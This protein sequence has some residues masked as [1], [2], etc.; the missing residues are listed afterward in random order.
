MAE[1]SVSTASTEAGTTAVADGGGAPSTTSTEPGLLD[2]RSM[3]PAELQSD[4]TLANYKTLDAA[5]KTLIE[6]RKML[7]RALFLPEEGAADA[8]A[9]LAKVYDKLGRPADATQYKITPPE[10]PEGLRWDP[11]LEK[12]FREEAYVAGLTQTQVDRLLAFEARRTQQMGNLLQAR[13]AEQ[14]RASK[15]TLQKTFGASA[16]RMQ[17]EAIAFFEQFGRGAFGGDQGKTALEVF[18]N[19]YT[20]D[21][22]PLK[23]HPAVV[24]AFAQAY[25]CLSEDSFVTSE[26]SMAGV[27]NAEAMTTRARELTAKQLSGSLNASEQAELHKI[28][29]ARVR[30]REAQGGRVA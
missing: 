2:W 8:E 6:Q 4:K 29:Q 30:L 19:A 18:E 24:Y 22:V 23:N 25:K 5:A 1:E 12:Q 21:G 20:A 11:E 17:Q 26:Y 16:A 15:E 10:L 9:A 14:E 28:N 3:L 7:G 27:S 13:I